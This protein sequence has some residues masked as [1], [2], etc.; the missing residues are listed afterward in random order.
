MKYLHPSV[1]MKG[2]PITFI[3]KSLNTNVSTYIN[4]LPANY[5]IPHVTVSLQTVLSFSIYRTVE[6]PLGLE[7]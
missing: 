3:S 5:W 1:K 2:F 7:D 6:N 4:C